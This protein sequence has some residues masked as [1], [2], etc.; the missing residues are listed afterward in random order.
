[1]TPRAQAITEF[2]LALPVLLMLLYGVLET[3]RLLFIYGSTVTASRQAVRYGSATGI[4]PNGVPYYQDCVGILEAAKKVSFINRFEDSDILITYDE[5]PQDA[6]PYPTCG[7]LTSV[8]N[9][10]RIKVSVSTQW[11]PIVSLLPFKPFQI[12]SESE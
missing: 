5:G 8:E 4:S 12:N 6:G 1:M 2:A 10:D 7:T 11:T 9:G 3:G